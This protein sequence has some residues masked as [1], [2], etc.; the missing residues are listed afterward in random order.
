[1]VVSVL[2]SLGVSYLALILVAC[3]TVGPDFE[4]PDV[5]WVKEWQSE[6]YAVLSDSRQSDSRQSDSGQ[7]DSGQSNSAERTDVDLRFWWQ[8]F[9]DPTLA[10]LIKTAR[11]D[12]LALQVAGLR[13]LEARA[14]LG[15][16]NA[17]QYPQVQQ[18][19]GS[20]AWVSSRESGGST[21]SFADYQAGFGL[22]W[23]LD[24]WG[25]FRR[26]IESADAAFFASLANQQDAQVLLTAAIADLYFAYI[27]AQ[28]RIAI[29]Q[30]N[31][32]IQERSLQITEELYQSGQESELDLQQAKTQYLSTLSSIPELEIALVN[33][34]NALGALL[35]RPPGAIP[36]LKDISTDLP[37][38][39]PDIIRDLPATLLTRR[40]DIRS[41]AW[42]VAAQSA[43]IGVAKADYYPAI[44]LFGN[45][46]WSGNSISGS[47]DT[48][49]LG[50]GPA[51]TWNVFD[52][53]RIGNNVRVQD[54]RL[55]QT[56]IAYQDRVI[57]AAREIDDAAVAVVKTGVRKEILT[58][59]VEAA[60]RSLEIANARYREGYADF[61]RVLDAQRA[62]FSQT[63]R[64]LINRG[65]HIGAVVDLYRAL[66]G[67]WLETPIEEI[68]PGAVRTQLSERT[69]WGDLLQDPL[70][71][72]AAPPIEGR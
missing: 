9:D 34:H 49:S 60:T 13:V 55:Q 21:D 16:A 72:A 51:L 10:S 20:A 37:D 48:V 47:S 38:V 32:R 63:E 52:Y 1:L 5:E 17:S 64:E 24:F 68:V 59:S 53:G 11:V 71:P 4:E 36:E 2:R 65:N 22:G 14:R 69:D 3:T 67:G 43:Q 8:V 26:S 58:E 61:Q 44:S 66:G 31:A 56:I 19:N 18:V 6:H 12:S 25:R 7:S 57:Q 42:Q 40:P 70:P 28:Q 33:V 39:E 41:A 50:L 45:L 27:T 15:I 54:A 35:G 30:N 29:A 62:L 46:G 23:E